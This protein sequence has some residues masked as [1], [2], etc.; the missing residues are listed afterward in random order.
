MPE[1]TAPGIGRESSLVTVEAEL[2]DKA[3]GVLCALG[4]SSG[5]V[6]LFMDQ[7]R[8]NYEYNMM[9]IERYK[10]QTEAIPAGKH[11]IEV[12]NR[13]SFRPSRSPVSRHDR[14]RSME[15]PTKTCACPSAVAGHYASDRSDRCRRIAMVM[16][17]AS[18]RL[19]ERGRLL[20]LD[21]RIAANH[22][23]PWRDRHLRGRHLLRGRPAGTAAEARK[24]ARELAMPEVAETPVP[25]PTV[26]GQ[27]EEWLPVGVWAL[28]QHEQGDAT[29]FVQL[30][31]D[32]DGLVAG[33]FKNIMTGDEL[34]IIGRLDRKTQ[35]VAWHFGEAAQ[36]VY[37]TGLSSL[38]NDVASVF[39]HFGENQ[40]QTWLLVRLPSPEI[41]P[42]TVKLPEIARQQRAKTRKETQEE[43]KLTEIHK[44]GQNQSLEFQNKPPRSLLTPVQFIA[45]S[46]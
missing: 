15:K 30:S 41:P 8:L 26:E 22:L 17:V 11:V 2:G 40:T 29:M 20:R 43:A 32:K 39:V 35:R 14:H 4:G 19:D 13:F 18:F 21:H 31:I 24:A 9:I 42:G 1:F 36:T 3:S 45:F 28:I 46:I 6:T 16:V 44:N 7:G 38:Q 27:P 37:E 25:D 23:R 34:P 5:G 33:A 10:A 12:E